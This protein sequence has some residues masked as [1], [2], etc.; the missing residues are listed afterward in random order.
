MTDHL[1]IICEQ[2]S[3]SFDRG[4]AIDEAVEDS[5]S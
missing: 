3:L 2:F 4:K 1:A 5:Q